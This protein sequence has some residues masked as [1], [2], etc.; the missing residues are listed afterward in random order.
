MLVALELT[1]DACPAARPFPIARARARPDPLPRVP[2][3]R[4]VSSPPPQLPPWRPISSYQPSHTSPPKHPL[5]HSNQALAGPHRKN[6]PKF[7]SQPQHQKI[8]QPSRNRRRQTPAP[9]PRNPDRQPTSPTVKTTQHVSR[10]RL[11]LAPAH[12]RQGRPWLVRALPSPSSSSPMSATQ[13][14]R[15]RK[16]RRSKGVGTNDGRP[17]QQQQDTRNPRTNQFANLS[18]PPTAV[19]A[20]TRPV[21][22]AS[23][24]STSAVSAS[25]RSPPTLASSRCVPTTNT[26]PNPPPTPILTTPAHQQHR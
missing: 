4:L 6:T 8:R 22:S 20:P 14:R 2:S 13:W 19:S 17:W 24:A 12:L 23:T 11:E 5:S 15:R 21:S 26:P 25:A 3:V 18:P 1:A 16:R 9:S 7:C 10:I